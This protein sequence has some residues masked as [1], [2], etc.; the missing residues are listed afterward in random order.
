MKVLIAD[1]DAVALARAR[2]LCDACGHETYTARDGAAAW[3]TL[4]APDGPRLAIV[5][6]VMPEIEGPELC[7]RLRADERLASTY[8]VL[9]TSN[10]RHADRVAGLE[11][12]ADDYLTKPFDP[13][14]L[15]ARLKVGERVL[16]LRT[17][18]EERVADLEAALS[19]VRRLE[20]L[21]PMCA[22]CKRV[23]NEKEYWQK[24]DDYV[25]S[26]SGKRISHGM[27]PECFE[28]EAGRR[29][30]DPGVT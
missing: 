19:R 12:G 14:E 3:R 25:E 6:W 24:V 13:D 23:R 9:L 1:E 21:L 17:K 7:K 8:V 5:D 16:A 2:A 27:C 29:A 26:L 20:T 15:R 4:R 30:P 18:L 22:W 28:R 10:D 11:A